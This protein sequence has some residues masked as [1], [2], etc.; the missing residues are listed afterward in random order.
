MLQL[1]G[2]KIIGKYP[3]KFDI[4]WLL[5]EDFYGMVKEKWQNFEIQD[6]CNPMDSLVLKLNLLKKEVSRWIK[7]QKKKD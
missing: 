1:D 2:I 6:D 4:F 3:F 7:E 5:N